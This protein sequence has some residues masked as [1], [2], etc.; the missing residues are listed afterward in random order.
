MLPLSLCGWGFH[1]HF[2]VQPPTTVEAEV[3]LRLS[4]GCDN[5][6]FIC[7]DNGIESCAFAMESDASLEESSAISPL[8]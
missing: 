4:W 2:R 1:S 3:R 6:I 8:S 7:K 5:R